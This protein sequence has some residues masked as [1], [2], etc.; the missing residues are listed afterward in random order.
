MLH[1]LVNLLNPALRSFTRPAQLS[2]STALCRFSTT[3]PSVFQDYKN[4]ISE[5]RYMILVNFTKEDDLSFVENRKPIKNQA[6]VT[7]DNFLRS[8]EWDNKIREWSSL[9]VFQTTNENDKP[10]PNMFTILTK[11]DEQGLPYCVKVTI[12]KDGLVSSTCVDVSDFDEP[13]KTKGI[14]YASENND[15]SSSDSAVRRAF[16]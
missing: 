7:L 13:T 1:K 6:R 3:S 14:A 16:K 9:G 12:S 5:A 10:A 4:S 8:K 11:R 15:S 2:H